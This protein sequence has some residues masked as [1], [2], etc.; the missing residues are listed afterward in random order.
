M[1]GFWVKQEVSLVSKLKKHP[2]YPNHID[3]ECNSYV[4]LT[5]GH[6]CH[7][8]QSHLFPWQREEIIHWHF[9]Y[10]QRYADDTQL[11]LSSLSRVQ[12]G[13]ECKSL[14]IKTWQNTSSCSL[15]SWLV[16]SLFLNCNSSYKPRHQS[17][18][19]IWVDAH[20]HRDAFMKFNIGRLCGAVSVIGSF[21]VPL[22]M[23]YWSTLLC[24][25]LLWIV[26]CDDGFFFPMRSL[27]HLSSLC[28]YLTSDFPRPPHISFPLFSLPLLSF[29]RSPRPF[30]LPLFLPFSLLR[31]IPLFLL[32]LRAGKQD[33]AEQIPAELLLLRYTLHWS[34]LM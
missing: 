12:N 1:T 22:N 6:L 3:P 2:P 25:L 10:Y 28:R 18:S 34:H 5:T 9:F 8:I 11:Y 4:I 30:Y 33:A 24:M 13:L 27:T 21:F 16:H 17:M 29:L 15:I 32:L 26:S 7:S 31:S 14:S 19:T 23:D 20:R